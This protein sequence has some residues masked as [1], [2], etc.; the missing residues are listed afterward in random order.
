MKNSFF[1]TLNL[2]ALL[3]AGCSSTPTR[4]DKGPIHAATFSFI[5]G[6]PPTLRLCR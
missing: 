5:T 4:V 6:S 1:I 2:A 3:L